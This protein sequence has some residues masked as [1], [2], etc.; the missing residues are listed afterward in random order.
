MPDRTLA[1]QAAPLR[2]HPLPSPTQVALSNG[3]PVWLLPFGETPVVEVQAIFRAGDAYQ[4]KAGVAEYASSCLTEGT[5]SYNSQQFAEQLDAYGASIHAEAGNE[6][7]AVSL[8]GLTHDLPET[9]P[10]LAE[11]LLAPT[12]PEE[13]FLNMQQ[14]HLQ[15]L[16]VE[17]IRTNWMARQLFGELLWGAQHPYGMTLGAAELALLTP[18]DLPAYHR[19]YLYPGNFSLAVTG[20]F[21]LDEVMVL[22]EMRFGGLS[23]LPALDMPSAA[24]APPLN[25]HGRHL[26]PREGLQSTLRI[27]HLGLSRSHADHYG[28]EVVNTVLGGY[29]GSR[30]MRKLREEMA[31]TYGVYSGWAA[32]RYG[33]W[34]V[35]QADVANENAER[36]LQAAREQIR[37]LQQDGV[38][39]DELDLVKN[40]LLGRSLNSRENAFRIADLLRFSL[41]NDISFAEIDRRFDVVRDISATEVQELAQRHLHPEDMLEVVSGAV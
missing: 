5:A 4:P 2:Y 10:L 26:A 15:Q 40:Y 23:L 32:E 22:L 3:L 7:I 20:R 38:E 37:R 24:M 33:G 9:L 6:L 36:A 28:M 21:E 16:E 12:F 29:Y 11:A 34:F 41:G 14:R 8:S 18:D 25:Q 19:Q 1:P 35:V 17:Q 30:L 13:E 27:G 31:L 39:Q